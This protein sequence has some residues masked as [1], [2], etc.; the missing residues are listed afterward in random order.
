MKQVIAIAGNICAGKT[1]LAVLLAERLNGLAIL[2]PADANPYLADFY[3]DMAR[4]SFHSQVFFL[5]R[6]LLQYKLAGDGAELVINDRTSYEDAEIFAR[7]LHELGY[8]S[9][10]DWRTYRDIYEA[11][12]GLIVTPSL[13]VYLTAS[14]PTLVGRVRQRG[15]DYERSI[16]PDYLSSLTKL[17]ERWAS[18]FTLC[19]L[20]RIDTE[21]VDYVHDPRAMDNVA[22]LIS[23]YLAVPAHPDA[24]LDYSPTPR[25][26]AG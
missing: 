12:R 8:L 22:N 19:P 20:V 1:S 14:V 10:R 25:P 17:Y 4:W 5:S 13:V 26:R 18:E 24:L 16:T 15:I 3:D 21:H 2:E 23:G 7:D 9:E 11:I 6:R